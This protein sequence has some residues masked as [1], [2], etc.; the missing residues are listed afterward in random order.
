MKSLFITID[1]SLLP[2]PIRNEVVK[3]VQKSKN[4]YLLEEQKIKINNEVLKNII[5]ILDK[6]KG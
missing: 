3:E 5:P 4:H 2:L 1:L 6:F